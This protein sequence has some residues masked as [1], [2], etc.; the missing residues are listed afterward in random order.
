[1]ALGTFS[2]KSVRRC[3]LGAAFLTASTAP[4]VAGDFSLNERI[5]KRDFIKVVMSAEFGGDT[6]FG[7]SV[8]KYVERVRFAVI[9]HAQRDR[10]QEVTNFIQSLPGKIS[11][12]KIGFANSPQRANFRIHIVDKRQYTDVMQRYVYRDNK[13]IAR[14]SCFVRV[15]PGA[16][17]IGATDAVIV[18][19]H[20][21]R[22]FQRCLV[23]EVLQGL[24]PLADRAHHRYSVFNSQST[25][26]TF[27][28]H[29]QV[30]LNALYDERIK[31]GMSKADVV[32]VLPDVIRDSIAK[33]QRERT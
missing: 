33:I 4:S 1:M 10:S 9:N 19:D 29:D 15:M 18:A 12:L 24:G 5:L 22:T 7:R 17:G 20:G 3:I 13:A 31:P 27:T 30:L 14:S 28:P 21:E 16:V 32:K 6:E 11:G 25:H 26:T 23:E 8:K 2:A